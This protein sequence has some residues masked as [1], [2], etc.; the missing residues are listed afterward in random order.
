MEK[1]TNLLKKYSV[2][3][4]IGQVD[5]DKF[6]ED[7]V[8][9]PESYT[10]NFKSLR[11]KRKDIERLPDSEK[12]DCCTVSLTP[13]KFFLEE[14]MHRIGDTL[15]L[16]LRRNL[17][18]EFKEID[19]FLDFANERLSTRPH[20]IA[21]IGAAKRQWKEI[22]DKKDMMKG[23]SKMCVDKKK[24]LLQYAPGTAVDTSEVTSRMSNL[25][26]EG[27]RWD[28][29]DIS[30]EAFNDMVEE[31][32]EALKGT[33]EEDVTNL[34]MSIDKFG[35]R[36]KQLKP[37]DIKSWEYSEIQKVFESLGDWKKQ[38]SELE[39][40]SI[41]L[42][43][44]CLTFG[45]AKPRFDGLDSLVDDL[46]NTNKS[47]DMLKDY[48]DE[49]YVMSSQD[50]LAFSVNVYALQDFA[51]KWLDILKS[52]F[53]KGSYD[54]IAEHIISTVEKIKKSIPA[55]KY[56][57][58]EPFKEDHW[59]ELLQGTFTVIVFCYSNYIYS[60]CTYTLLSVFYYCRYHCHLTAVQFFILLLFIQSFF[61]SIINTYT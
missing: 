15:L 42:S 14:L 8:D 49:L 45:L 26:G 56:C 33:L 43:E 7:N 11:A 9:Q 59:T 40:S 3:V 57:Q 12:I 28:D 37:T 52:I 38:F 58:G 17:L 21:E 13:F 29:F 30:L 27:G 36:W 60:Y 46:K 48:Y 24:L 20:S 18:V 51:M 44:N 23:S 47:W 4:K 5:L 10:N 32:K 34:N 50:W 61:A 31:Q 39:S 35:K 55:L 53:I 54:S 16:V 1:L 41:T 19:Q 2:W 25:D 22:D 6:I